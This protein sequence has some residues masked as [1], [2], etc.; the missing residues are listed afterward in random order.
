MRERPHIAVD[1]PLIVIENED[2]L[3]RGGGDVVE[4][5][6]RGA[7]GEGAISHHGDDVVIIAR[8]VTGGG[9]AQGCGKR[10]AGVAGAVGIVLGFTALAEPAEPAMLADGVEL[11]CP[12]CQQ[13]VHIALV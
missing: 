10:G 2:E 13:F 9:H 7:A 8:Q 3:A 1:A 5:F 6:Q 11:L 12:A 4:S